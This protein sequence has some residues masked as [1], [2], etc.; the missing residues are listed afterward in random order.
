MANIVGFIGEDARNFLFL[1]L[2]V[3]QLGKRSF[4]N[5]HGSVKTFWPDNQPLSFQTDNVADIETY[6]LT[7]IP[8][9]HEQ[10]C[11]DSHS[12]QVIEM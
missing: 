7:L 8:K 11:N 12:I 1:R 4:S 10:N 9:S 6:S 3:T 5:C 2:F